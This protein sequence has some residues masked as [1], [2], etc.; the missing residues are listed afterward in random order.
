MGI[1]ASEEL[2][3]PAKFISLMLH[4]LVVTMSFFSYVLPP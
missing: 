2:L 4:L 3:I 1:D